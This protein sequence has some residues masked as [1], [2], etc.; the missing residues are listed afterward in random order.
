MDSFAIT[1][2][3]DPK[4][5]AKEPNDKQ[6]VAD[7]HVNYWKLPQYRCCSSY[8]RFVD[9]GIMIHEYANYL[10]SI[11]VFLPFKIR[12]E[13]IQD[14]GGR[15]GGS[16]ELLCSL[17]NEE[18][19]C[20]ND[21][22]A[23]SYYSVNT[24]PG[25]AHKPFFIYK[26]DKENF[27]VRDAGNGSLVNIK[28]LTVPSN[29][30]GLQE[31]E[32]KGTKDIPLANLYLRFRIEKVQKNTFCS[33]TSIQ[34]D[35]LQKA[36]SKIEYLDF[37]VNRRRDIDGKV[38]EIIN[39]EYVYLKYKKIHFFFG[40]SF[41][42]GEIEGSLPMKDT[43]IIDVSRWGTYFNGLD[44]NYNTVMTTHHWETKSEGKDFKERFDLFFRTKYSSDSL[45][46]ILWYI[47]IVIILG[48]AGSLLANKIQPEK[49][50]ELK[51]IA[52]YPGLYD[53]RDMEVAQI[54]EFLS[55]A[56]NAHAIGLFG[57]V[58]KQYT[59]GI[60][61]ESNYHNSEGL[62]NG[63]CPMAVLCKDPLT[64]KEVI[65]ELIKQGYMFINLPHS[66]TNSVVF[67][68]I[69]LEDAKDVKGL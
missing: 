54:V 45:F 16:T 66:S 17:F 62:R 2:K 44:F 8:I 21:Q 69:K 19:V 46:K 12:Q 31:V 9:I 20:T 43:R 30:K 26:L 24:P 48:A 61:S 38:Q 53:A 25:S 55:I 28:I 58:F 3:L 4:Q 6:V 37:K 40:S 36:F 33:I 32:D 14:L 29:I 41:K 11:Q 22:N 52:A 63:N 56:H 50:I 18:F 65:T 68:S 34:N 13:Q 51:A 39:K 42:D 35:V 67:I 1:Y 64:A 10:N 59:C 57:T 15:I 7:L 60:T 5:Q 27:D 47:S 23:K 49:T